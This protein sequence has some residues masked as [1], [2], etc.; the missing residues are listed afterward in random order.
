MLHTVITVHSTVFSDGAFR[1]WAFLIPDILISK[2]DFKT[3]A[4]IVSLLNLQH[5][6][7]DTDMGLNIL[8]FLILFQLLS[9]CRHMDP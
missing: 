7:A 5:P 2:N 4:S 6:V 8:H 1:I 9:Q 3:S